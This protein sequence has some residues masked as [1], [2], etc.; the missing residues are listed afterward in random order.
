MLDTAMRRNS[1]RL[2]ILGALTFILSC[3]AYGQHALHGQFLDSATGKPLPFVNAVYDELGHGFT[4]DLQGHFTIQTKAPITQLTVSYIGYRTARIPVDEQARR[5]GIRVKLA[6]VETA[7]E[8]VVVRASENPALR[9]LRQVLAAKKR[10]DPDGLEGYGFTAYSKLTAFADQIKKAHRIKKLAYIPTDE[11]Q[12]RNQLMVNETVVKHDYLHGQHSDSVIASRTS[13]FQRFSLPILPNSFQSLSFYSPELELLGKKYLNP[14]SEAGLGQYWFRLRDTMIDSQGDTVFTITFRPRNE[15][16]P[17]SITGSLYINTHD[18]ALQ[19]AMAQNTVSL[20]SGFN[21]E[22]KQRYTLYGD[23]IRIADELRST[24]WSTESQLIL[25]VESYLKDVSLLPPPPKRAWMLADVDFGG[26]VGAAH[27]SLLANHR[28]TELTQAD[29]ITYRIVD[30]VGEAEKLD[31]KIEKFAP[32]M[33]G[34]IPIGPVNLD[35]SKILEF[36]YFER[37]RLGLGLVTNERLIRRVRLGGYGA[38]GFHDRHW[39]YGGSVRFRLHPATDTYLQASYQHDVAVPGERTEDR[40]FGRYLSR[41]YIAHMDYTT[42]HEVVLGWR[43]PGRLRFWL[44]G[45]YERV[46]NLTGLG[47]TT[48]TPDNIKRGGSADYRLGIA[49]FGVRWA[50]KSYLALFPDGLTEMGAGSPVLRLQSEVGFAWGDWARHYYRGH[51][52]LLHTA[53]SAIYGT[54]H[55]RLNGMV[56]LGNYPLAKGFLTSGGGGDRFNYLYYTSFVTI[57][58]GEFYHDAQVEWHALYNSRPWGS[59]P[60]TEKWQPSLAVAANAGWGIQWNATMRADGHRYPDMHLGYYEVGLGLAD[61]LPI[62][63]LLPISNLYLLCYYR[64]GP[65]MDANWLRNLAFVLTAE[66]T[67]F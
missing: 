6:P 56:V 3:A 18:Y 55:T 65:Y 1:T 59:I 62:A 48:L 11:T 10:H 19:H 50:P 42:R 27:D 5:D 14:L 22:V 8:Q 58:P 30:S 7:I 36:N 45:R 61:P 38:Y 15:T 37:V 64:V 39:K 23:S 41:L 35:L 33:E 20:I 2:A 31:N 40:W 66:T 47:F 54:L 32:I 53:N 60:I 52:E 43:T 29:S 28:T 26:R 49:A 34:Q 12:G 67:L 17:N 57:R 44:S 63:Q 24:V 25:E 46:K 16:N 13:G 9:I 21:F 4:S 51:A